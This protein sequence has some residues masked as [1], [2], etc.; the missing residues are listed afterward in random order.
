MIKHQRDH[1]LWL[2]PDVNNRNCL[3]T[4]QHDSWP[5]WLESKMPGKFMT[6]CIRIVDSQHGYRHDVKSL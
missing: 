3:F 5:G 1:A 4:Q 2:F 6:G